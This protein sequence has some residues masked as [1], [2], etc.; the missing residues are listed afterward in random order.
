C[1]Y[2]SSF[3]LLFFVYFDIFLFVLFF[4]FLM[5]RR[6]PRSTLFPYTTLF[7]SHRPRATGLLVLCETFCPGRSHVRAHR[8]LEPHRA[9]VRSL[10][11]VGQMRKRFAAVHLHD[12]SRDLAVAARTNDDLLSALPNSSRFALNARLHSGYAGAGA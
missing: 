3:V 4:F 10:G 12:G 8:L 9:P 11:V 2:L 1:T 7:R 5:I 6:P